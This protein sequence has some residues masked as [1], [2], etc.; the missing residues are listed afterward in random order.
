MMIMVL[1]LGQASALV[2]VPSPAEV[3][4]AAA[5][6]RALSMPLGSPGRADAGRRACCACGAL[7]FDTMLCASC[8]E[9]GGA[10]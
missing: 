8:D 9:S 3:R 10:S 6:G 5:L 7:V 2:N 4:Q 1:E